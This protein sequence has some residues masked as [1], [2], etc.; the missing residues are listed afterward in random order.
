M[1]TPKEDVVNSSS[2][3]DAVEVESLCEEN[4]FVTFELPPLYQE[5]VTGLPSQL[6]GIYVHRKTVVI[7]SEVGIC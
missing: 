2:P 5:L 1:S 6:Q 3:V 4:F 7:Y